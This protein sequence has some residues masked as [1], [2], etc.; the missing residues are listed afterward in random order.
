MTQPFDCHAE[1]PK[2]R[3]VDEAAG[4][5]WVPNPWDFSVRR[6]NL[7][8]YERNGVFLNLG[9]DRFT[10]IGFLTTADSH[11]DGRSAVGCDITGDGMPELFVRQAGGGALR[12]YRN[13]FPAASWLTVTLEG[14]ASNR[15]GIGAK[16]VCHAGKRVVRRE[17]YPVANFLSQAPARITLGLHEA[18]RIDRLEVHW[19]SGTIQVLEDLPVNRRLHIRENDTRPR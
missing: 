16:L 11:G 7:S 13:N 17:L 5:F 14:D 19:P 4:E 15:Q 18:T 12:V 8:A 10:E 2:L 3:E 1:V 9:V 6:E